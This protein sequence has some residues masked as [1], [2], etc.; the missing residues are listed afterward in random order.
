MSLLAKKNNI[1]LWFF[2]R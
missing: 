2:F 1:D